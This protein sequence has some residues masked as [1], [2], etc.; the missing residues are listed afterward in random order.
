MPQTARRSGWCRPFGRPT[1]ETMEQATLEKPP[2]TIAGDSSRVT[3]PYQQ[4]SQATL[5]EWKERFH[6][7]GFLFLKGVLQPGFVQRLRADFDRIV[8][9]DGESLGPERPM[10]LRNRMFER[11]RAAL[12]LFD[13]EPIVTF[14]EQLV[15]AN[16]HVFHNNFFRTAAGGGFSQ[17][18]QDD[19][20]HYLVTHGTAP[21]NVRLAVL[22]FTCNYFL[23]DA[24]S[25]EHGT[26]QLV[27]G[28]HLFGRRPPGA[29]A[30]ELPVGSG[31]KTLDGTEWSEKV[32]TA[33]GPAGS[34][35][36]F[37]NQTWHRGAP[38]VSDRVRYVA[39]VSYGRRVIGHRYFPYMNYRMPEEVYRDASPRLKRLLGFLPKGPYG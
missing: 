24:E 1:V 3:E 21:T 38:N 28:S 22:F 4:T 29:E 26:T 15:A 7:D 19:D 32:F 8:E 14:A 25:V 5:E 31:V 17:W 18:H 23:T 16:C 30:S 34:V 36:L 13:L 6:R 11:S 37:N 10:I 35:I 2:S 9:E 39:Q 27:P 20:A 12:Q 33:C